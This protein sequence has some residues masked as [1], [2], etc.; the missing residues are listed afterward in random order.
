MF[1]KNKRWGR[2][3]VGETLARWPKQADGALEPPAFLCHSAGDH[4]ADTILRNMLE[5][6]GIPSVQLNS[7]N[8]DLGEIFS[9]IS[10]TGADIFVPESMYADAKALLEGENDHENI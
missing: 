2:K 7:D 1:G 6:F 8:G 3:P 10:M 4:M 5:S 9:G